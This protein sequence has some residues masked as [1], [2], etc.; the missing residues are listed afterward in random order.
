MS[1]PLTFHY[2]F[3]TSLV[4]TDPD[5]PRKIK[6]MK[7]A[8]VK[9]VWLDNYIYG[10]WQN[11]L[12]DAR[13]AKAMLEDEGFEVQAI[14]V[15]LG[16]GSNALNGDEADPTLPDA[17]QNRLDAHGNRQGTTTCVDDTVISWYKE[18]V[19]IHKD[20]GFTKLFYDDD[21]RMGSWG[22]HLQGCY[23]PRCLDRFYKKYPQY[24]GMKPPDIVTYAIEGDDLWNAW[25]D[26]Q[27]DAILRFLDE[28]TPEGLTPGI[29][30]MHN[31]DRRHGLDIPRIKAHFPGAL[32]R[33]G[34]GHFDDGSFGSPLCRPSIETCIKKH[35]SLIGSVENAFSETT[36][37]PVGALSP[38]NWIEKMR[39]EIRCGLRNLF[40]MSGNVFLTDPYWEALIAA[41]AELESLAEATPLPVLAEAPCEDDF[42]WH[43]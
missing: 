37:Y 39:W 27:C 28:T 8:G 38:E 40:L 17:W 18:A 16:H 2:D 14:C 7:R 43:L 6:L 23:C 36:T 31:G 13:R 25:T 15:P 30:V 12:E 3:L 21:L 34:E 10:E 9:T 11:S 35:L 41:R 24:D 22:P 33:V 20:L 32:F 29:M 26:I 42:V 5:F 19:Q 1:V 4:L